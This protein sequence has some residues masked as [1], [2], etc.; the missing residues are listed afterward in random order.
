M[1]IG[2]HLSTLYIAACHQDLN[3]FF[4]WQKSVLYIA[5]SLF[6]Y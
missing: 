4:T 6:N 5:S 2:F 1:P 3:G